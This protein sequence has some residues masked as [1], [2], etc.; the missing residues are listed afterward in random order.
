VCIEPFVVGLEETH[1]AVLS[2]HPTLANEELWIDAPGTWN[3]EVLDPSGRT[4][5]KH[6]AMGNGTPIPLDALAIGLYHL[7]AVDH[8]G[9][10]RSAR[11]VKVQ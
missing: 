5:S 9:T 11:F 6:A 8:H 4:C 2:I 7:R 10:M 3:V 1:T